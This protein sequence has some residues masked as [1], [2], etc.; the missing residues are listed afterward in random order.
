VSNCL[1]CV[2]AYVWC[3]YRRTV[4]Q[5]AQLTPG[6][7]YYYVVVWCCVILMPYNKQRTKKV[8]QPTCAWAHTTS[9]PCSVIESCTYRMQLYTQQCSNQH[10][11]WQQL[12]HDTPSKHAT[13]DASVQVRAFR[14]RCH[15]SRGF[16]VAPLIGPVEGKGLAA[17]V[18][19]AGCCNT[20]DCA[21]HKA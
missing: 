21:R 12:M 4:F 20:V 9:C 6:L 14:A 18:L 5:H 2:C 1:D 15:T 3:V 16:E 7:L 17:C 19:Q 11:L 13:S 8:D 10:R